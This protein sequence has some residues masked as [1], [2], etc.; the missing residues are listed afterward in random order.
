MWKA[1]CCVG[2]GWEGLG[3]GIEGMVWK[4]RDYEMGFSVWRYVFPSVTASYLQHTLLLIP[5]HTD[6]VDIFRP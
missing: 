6:N 1:G 5:P 4:A 3:Y 2:E